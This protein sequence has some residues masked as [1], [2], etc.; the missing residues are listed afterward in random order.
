MYLAII[1]VFYSYLKYEEKIKLVNPVKANC[2]LRV[3]KPLPR[4]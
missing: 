1:R 2:R 3:P 4:A